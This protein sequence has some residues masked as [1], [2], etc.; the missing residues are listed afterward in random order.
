M[1][2]GFGHSNQS[3]GQATSQAILQSAQVQERLLDQ[4]LSKY[5]TLLDDDSALDRIR[6]QRLAQMKKEHEQKK[7]WQ[8]AGHGEYSELG[9]G[10]NLDVAKEFFAATKESDNVVVHFY[11]PSTRICDVFHKHLAL[12]AP[13]HLET[14]F[15]KINVEDCDKTGG[16]ASFLVE[17]LGVVVMPT[18]VLIRKRQMQHHVRGFDELGNSDD[19][20]TSRLAQVL[21]EHGVL[22]LTDAEREEL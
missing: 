20:A 11:R 8:N 14:R 9:G 12:L 2:L 13:Q 3:V 16:G 17:R 4:E 6:A 21:E 15:C 1:D 18:L 5:D 10:Q 22:Q 19:F 7:Q